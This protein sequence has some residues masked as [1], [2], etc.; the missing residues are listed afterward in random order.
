MR[1]PFVG[2]ILLFV[3][4]CASGRRPPEE[5]IEDGLPPWQTR[6]LEARLDIA[7]TFVEAGDSLS[8]LEIIR[9][10]RSEGL[11]SGELD[12]LQGRALAIDGVITE[13]ERLLL[14]AAKRMPRDDRPPTELCL[15]YGEE[16]EVTKAIEQ[17]ERATRL[18][19][20]NAKAW[21]NLGALLL[22]E[23][24]FAEAAEAAQ[25]AVKLDGTT[26]LYR[27]NLGLTQVARGRPELAFRTFQST[28]GR[29]DAA[30]MVGV[31]ASRFQDL[32]EAEAWYR[33]AIEIEPDNSCAK[34]N[35]NPE[36]G[37]GAPEGA[38]EE[39]P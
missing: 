26:A 17:C 18:N 38:A 36:K 34:Q 7:R 22:T 8:A 23:A 9:Q 20:D 28:M 16:L 30:C 39:V 32:G 29:A 25:Q 4:G 3:S 15:L 13:A 10:V 5:A 21:N 19:E 37:S 35:L 14:A 6:G 12:L 27:N 24:R 33:R 31:A 2:L 1:S 11:D